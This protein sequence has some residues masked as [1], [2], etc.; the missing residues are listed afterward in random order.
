[1]IILTADTIVWTAFIDK[2][3]D[4]INPEKR[5]LTPTG[6]SPIPTERDVGNAAYIAISL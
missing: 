5:I 1:M 6:F 3:V 4:K 2:S